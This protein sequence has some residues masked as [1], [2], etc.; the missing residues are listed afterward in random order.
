MVIVRKRVDRHFVV[1]AVRGNRCG[2]L[3]RVDL[4]RSGLV[5][6]IVVALYGISARSKHVGADLFAL[7]AGYGV[8]NAALVIVSYKSV[9]LHGKFIRIVSFVILG[10]ILGGYRHRCAI[11][12]EFL[13]RIAA[14]VVVRLSELCICDV[15]SGILRRLGKLRRRAVVIYFEVCNCN[16]GAVRHSCYFRLHSLSVVGLGRIRKL[17]GY[18]IFRLNKNRNL[19]LGGLVVIITGNRHF[20]RYR[21]GILAGNK[22]AGIRI[23]GAAVVIAH[24][25]VGHLAVCILYIFREVNGLAVTNHVGCRCYRRAVLCLFN[26]ELRRCRSLLVIVRLRNRRGDAVLAGI[27]RL[28]YRLICAGCIFLFVGV[29]YFAVSGV[30]ARRELRRVGRLVVGPTVNGN[31]RRNLCLFNGKRCLYRSAVVLVRLLHR[32]AHDVFAGL[33]RNIGSKGIVIVVHQPVFDCHIA[34]AVI[35][36]N[37]RRRNRVIPVGPA[38]LGYGEVDGLLII[39]DNRDVFRLRLVILISGSRHLHG[40]GSGLIRGR[41]RSVLADGAAEILIDNLISDRT[42]CIFKVVRKIQRLSAGHTLGG[43]R[44]GQAV[45]GLCDGKFRRLRNA[46]VTII[47]LRGNTNHV[48]SGFRRHRRGVRVIRCIRLLV[49]RCLGCNMIRRLH[50]CNR[51]RRCDS[52]IAEG[53]SL[54]AH[55]KSR[56]SLVNSEGVG[57]GNIGIPMVRTNTVSNHIIPGF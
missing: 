49:E 41:Q 39:H 29:G 30:A 52:R 54:L 34:V 51:H 37:N 5:R 3:R 15:V 14:L 22:L 35:A 42:V 8:L 6:Y 43:N 44:H 28:F 20:N 4:E 12:G 33:R 53:P 38:L 9:N 56:L 13:F 17:Q 10:I 46:Y 11:D 1:L 47:F 40:D 19:C 26:R 48:V 31:R 2:I 16:I 32:D 23:H 18:R 27:L 25:C 55:R 36:G 57:R 50:A 24:D 7:C 45:L 21:S